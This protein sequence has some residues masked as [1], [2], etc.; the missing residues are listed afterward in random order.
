MGMYLHTKYACMQESE[1][2]SA[3]PPPNENL[4]RARIPCLP[5]NYSLVPHCIW[6]LMT[7]PSQH[8][9]SGAQQQPRWG[10][11]AGKSS[12]WVSCAVQRGTLCSTHLFRAQALPD[13]LA[14]SELQTLQQV[15]DLIFLI[16]CKNLEQFGHSINI[17]DSV[18]LKKLFIAA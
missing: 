2:L 9:I 8:P 3:V 6:S 1:I 7:F 13:F 5:L 14:L 18:L 10:T 12:S 4:P 16:V 17:V 15:C 11:G